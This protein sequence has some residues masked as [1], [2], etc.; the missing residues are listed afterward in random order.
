MRGSI[1]RRGKTWLLK[2]EGPKIDGKRNQRY[3]TVRGTRQD[4]QKELT[5][6]LGEA[7]ANKLPDATRDTVAAYLRTYLDSLTSVS[8]KTLERYRELAEQQ[9]L[10]A[11][12]WRQDPLLDRHRDRGMARKAAAQW[13]VA[14]HCHSCAPGARQGS[15]PRQKYGGP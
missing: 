13:P 6:L 1:I 8:P 9:G 3:C 12:R 11:S 10:P 5:R 7:D 2:F 4:A 15:A 14:A